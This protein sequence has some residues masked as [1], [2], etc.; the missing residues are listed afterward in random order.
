MFPK[1]WRSSE[2]KLPQFHGTSYCTLTLA[3]AQSP[4]RPEI[5]PRPAAGS[6]EQTPSLP[7]S[8]ASVWWV[9]NLSCHVPLLITFHHNSS[10][11]SIFETD[12]FP[13]QCHALVQPGASR[14]FPQMYL[15]WLHWLPHMARALAE[16]TDYKPNSGRRRRTK[17]QLRPTFIQI[18]FD[19][20]LNIWICEQ[21]ISK[22]I[23]RSLPDAK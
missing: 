7:S 1:C 3:A 15:I 6:P 4:P 2:F 21:S 8:A 12:P 11:L 17:W 9:V 20:C 16:V 5:D 18:I 10:H 19:S 22:A 23:H 14:N 13:H